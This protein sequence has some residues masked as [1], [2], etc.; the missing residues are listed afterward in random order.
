[1]RKRPLAGSE[2]KTPVQLKQS[3]LS[4]GPQSQLKLETPKVETPRPINANDFY[5]NATAPLRG[6]TWFGKVK[7]E[8]NKPYMQ[9]VF[10]RLDDE[11]KNVILFNCCVNSLILGKGHL[12]TCQPHLQCFHFD[13]V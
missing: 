5:A 1:M 7:D 3:K 6:T 12:S 2:N 9:K 10:K 13:S 4:F 11:A 8:L